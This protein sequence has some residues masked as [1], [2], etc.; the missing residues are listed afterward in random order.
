ML[1]LLP[2]DC[3]ISTP[4]ETTF[5]LTNLMKFPTML[6][7]IKQCVFKKFKTSSFNC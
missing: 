2:I 7:P 5:L 1:D 4:I 6:S 3:L